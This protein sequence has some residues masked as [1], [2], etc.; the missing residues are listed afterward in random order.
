MVPNLGVSQP[1]EQ[2]D[3]LDQGLLFC[4]VC[5]RGFPYL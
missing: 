3:I 4:I 5:D 1:E 2:P